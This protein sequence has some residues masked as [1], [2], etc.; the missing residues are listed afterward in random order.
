MLRT[1]RTTRNV[2]RLELLIHCRPVIPHLSTGAADR[3]GP[4]GDDVFR[5]GHLFV[6]PS[7]AAGHFMVTVPATISDR[8]AVA[9]REMPA[10]SRS[11]QSDWPRRPSFRWRSISRTSSAR[12]WPAVP[13][14]YL[15]E[16]GR[17][18]V[19]F[20]R[21]SIHVIIWS[22][23]FVAEHH[24]VGREQQPPAVAT[25]TPRTRSNDGVEATLKSAALRSPAVQ[26]SR[27]KPNIPIFFGQFLV[28]QLFSQNRREPRFL[29]RRHLPRRRNPRREAKSPNH[30]RSWVAAKIARPADRHRGC[31]GPCASRFGSSILRTSRLG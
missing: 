11:S 22:P 12:C 19:L 23:Y 24:H 4:H 9:S 21:P 20:S 18:H 29:Y 10:P 16:R 14:S 1:G 7:H 15:L 13:S 31:V 6:Q 8:L 3:A 28:G 30:I 25:R 17:N 5:V 2:R 27:S 26:T